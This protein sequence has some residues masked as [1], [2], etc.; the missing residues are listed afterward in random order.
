MNEA[1]FIF[2]SRQEDLN[3]QDSQ[4]SDH[5]NKASL[6]LANILVVEDNVVNQRITKRLLEKRGY[7]VAV[8]SS[9]QE[10]IEQYKRSNFDLTFMDIQMPEMN[11]YETTEAI[12]GFEKDSRPRLSAN[13]IYLRSDPGVTRVLR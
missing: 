11:G 12:R 9:G 4:I 2:Q 13:L 5:I 3:F 6:N 1:G 10:A 7:S 8:A